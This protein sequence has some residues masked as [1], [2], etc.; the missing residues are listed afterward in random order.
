MEAVAGVFFNAKDGYYSIDISAVV[1]T[2][3]E[4]D[5]VKLAT[6][7]RQNS[8]WSTTA[9]N[10]KGG[11]L[12][13][14]LDGKNPLPIDQALKIL[15]DQ[16]YDT[17]NKQWLPG[18]RQ[19][20]QTTEQEQPVPGPSKAEIETD[21]VLQTSEGKVSATQKAKQFLANRRN[22]LKALVKKA[23]EFGIPINIIHSDE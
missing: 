4:E 19:E 18:G 6:A 21:R 2:G 5:A 3:M 14:G 16:Y 13:T 1:P 8:V 10:G 23:M 11:L 20:G 9:N 15:T 7:L 17:E 22:S 12:N